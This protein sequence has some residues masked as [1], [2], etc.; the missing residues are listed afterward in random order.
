MKIV[1]KIGILPAVVLILAGCAGLNHSNKASQDTAKSYPKHQ[2]DG[3][4]E[5]VV[6]LQ[7]EL[8]ALEDT[9]DPAEART[10]AETAIRY[11]AHLAIQYNV[12]RPAVFH[13]ILVRIGVRDRGLCYQWT[14]D[15]IK[16]LAALN[17]KTYELHWGVAYRGSDLREHNTVVVTAN[18]YGIEQGIVLDPWRNSGELYWV[19]V[20][21][22]K[23]PWKLLPP[24]EW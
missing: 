11:S 19:A 2:T 3:Y 6:A 16:E 13:N 8:T 17:L 4:P 14:E 7:K 9:T 23:Y 1:S 21:E 15:L 5:K 20:K 12:V 10:V 18:G 24:Q 22:D